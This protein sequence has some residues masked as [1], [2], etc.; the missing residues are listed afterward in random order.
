MNSK[1]GPQIAATRMIP[2]L[3]PLSVNPNLQQEHFNLLM[4]TMKSMLTSIEEW[5]KVEFQSQAEVEKQMKDDQQQDFVKHQNFENLVDNE[6]RVKQTTNSNNI[7]PQR[8]VENQPPPS[9]QTLSSFDQVIKDEEEARLRH[10]QARDKTEIF[11]EIGGAPVQSS[12]NSS[13]KGLKISD[14]PV[15][16]D[17][18]NNN[19][20]NSKDDFGDF[21]SFSDSFKKQSRNSPSISSKNTSKQQTNDFDFGSF[22]SMNESND[23]AP[24]AATVPQSNS[25][26]QFSDL[27]NAPNTSTYPTDR[28]KQ[29][30]KT[31]TPNRESLFD[32]FNDNNNYTGSG[33]TPQPSN[34]QYSSQSNRNS[35][36]SFNQPNEQKTTNKESNFSYDLSND[37]FP[38]SNDNN[39]NFSFNQPDQDSSLYSNQPPS[40]QQNFGMFS[41]FPSTTSNIQ[42]TPN[43]SST[44]QFN[45]F[46]QNSSQ[47]VGVSQEQFTNKSSQYNFDFSDNNYNSNMTSQ[48]NNNQNQDNEFNFGTFTEDNNDSS[49]STSS[50]STS[51]FFS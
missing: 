38:P 18:E 12:S 50:F 2:F 14:S 9:E 47:N 41:D 3:A 34:T 8:R 30:Q 13:F 24:S 4:N 35:N 45:D 27:F 6:Y 33:N 19:N 43:N 11:H 42:S 15:N 31:N 21:S 25:N 49:W 46:T 36:Y 17:G 7:Q 28:S 40:G 37:Q 48:S 39:S 23:F 1:M 5:R 10:Y 22:D 44:N 26:S 32:N 29:E 51:N 16:W 20:S